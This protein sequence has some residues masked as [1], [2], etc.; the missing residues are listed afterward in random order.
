MTT[1]DVRSLPYMPLF[2]GRLLAS[3]TW[4]LASGDE[5]KAAVTLWARS[6]QQV[7]AGTLPNDERILAA[8]SGAGARW[9]KVRDVALRGFVLGADGR[10]HHQMIEEV[11]DETLARFAGYQTRTAAATAARKAK[12][13]QRNVQRNVQR[14]ERRDDLPREREEPPTVASQPTGGKS[15]ARERAPARPKAAGKT[16]LPANFAISDRVREWAASKGHSRLDERLE[17]FVGKARM[18][19]YRYAD[20]DEALMTAIRDD[21]AKLDGR[22]PTNG[23]AARL[24]PSGQQT[25][26]A[27]GRWIDDEVRDGTTGP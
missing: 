8:L 21:W 2:V 15:V 18:N 9:R 23:A 27:I 19:G 3:D 26:A 22:P 5:A 4:L 20:W 13:E 12:R 7:P 24:T 14:D 16:P 10:L 6:W 11:A 17:H 25:A 1:R